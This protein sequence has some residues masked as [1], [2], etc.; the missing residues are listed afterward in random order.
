MPILGLITPAYAEA[1]VGGPPPGAGIMNI[2]MLV[3]FVALFYFIVWRPQSKRAKAHKAL[4]SGLS[5][6]DEVL[7]SGGLVG[8]VTKVE[9]DFIVVQVADN[10]E[11]KV[12]RQAV[13][14][15]LPKGT[16]KSI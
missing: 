8:K 3:G 13:S 15:T 1:P 10:V 11:L 5:K 12:Q 9:D 6:G 7:T 14:A 16:L 2:A 4:V